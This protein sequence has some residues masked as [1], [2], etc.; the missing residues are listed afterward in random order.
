[1][2]FILDAVGRARQIILGEAL[3]R[4]IETAPVQ[5][6]YLFEIG[7][8]GVVRAWKWPILREVASSC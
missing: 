6:G 1:L 7:V 3:A 2:A 8:N 5:R 4:H